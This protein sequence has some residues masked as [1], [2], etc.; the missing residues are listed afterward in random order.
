MANLG[1]AQTPLASGEMADEF[2]ETASS[3]TPT[4]TGEVPACKVAVA[5]QWDLSAVLECRKAMMQIKLAPPP[6]LSGILY[7][8]LCPLS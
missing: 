5:M 7:A 2:T 1:E 3:E 8:S 6:R 4:P